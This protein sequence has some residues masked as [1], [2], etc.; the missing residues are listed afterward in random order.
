M[1]VPEERRGLG[2]DREFF[3]NMPTIKFFPGT[4]GREIRV[5]RGSGRG[6]PHFGP[7]PLHRFE[8]GHGKGKKKKRKKKNGRW[9]KASYGW[10]V[11]PCFKIPRNRMKGEGEGGRERIGISVDVVFLVKQ[12]CAGIYGD[13]IVK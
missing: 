1:A 9:K 3:E 12:K 2:D 5:F 13:R 7:A 11:A 4:R 10:I 6:Y 8:H